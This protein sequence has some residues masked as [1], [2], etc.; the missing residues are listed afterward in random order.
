MWTAFLA[1]Y[2]GLAT[3]GTG[4]ACWGG[5]QMVMGKRPWAFVGVPVVLVVVLGFWP[6][7]ALESAQGSS[8]SLF[9]GLTATARHVALPVLPPGRR[10]LH[11]GQARVRQVLLDP[12]GR[13]E[14]GVWPGSLPGSRRLG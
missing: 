6:T 5:A 7:P 12:G 3:V 1:I 10:N 11:H 14:P 4:A 8:H 13:H 9:E 2:L